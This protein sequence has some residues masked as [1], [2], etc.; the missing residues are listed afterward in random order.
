MSGG[1]GDGARIGEGG[2]WFLRHYFRGGKAALFSR[3]RYFYAG[4]TRVRAFAEF[5]MLAKLKELGLPAPKPIAARYRLRGLSYSADLITEWIAGSRT[6]AA[7]LRGA[8]DRAGLLARVGGTLARFHN[9]G[10]CHA[11]LNANNILIG[12]DGSVWLV[13]FDRARRRTP[14]GWRN[15]RLQRLKRSLE[16]LG[17]YDQE[18][19]NALRRQ[20]DRSLEENEDGTPFPGSTRRGK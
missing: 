19:F 7:A 2:R 20:H 15:S 5:R 10:V 3:D 16:K 14:G 11:D 18:A 9:T 4:E 13:D 12:R 17:L 6:L 1:R 8:E